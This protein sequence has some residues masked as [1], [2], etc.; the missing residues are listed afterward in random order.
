MNS[1]SAKSRFFVLATV[2]TF[3]LTCSLWAQDTNQTSSHDSAQQNSSDQA[4]N[5]LPPSKT[6]AETSKNAGEETDIQKRLNASAT[7]LDEIMKVPEKGIPQDAF[8]GAKCVVVIPST[9]KVAFVFGGEHGKGVATCRATK[10]ATSPW[11]APVPVD[12][13][14]GSWGLQIG[15]EAVDLVMLVMSEK[16]LDALLTNKF[17][18][19]ASASGAAGPVGRQASG[20]TDWKFKSDVLTYSRARGAFAGIDLNGAVVKQDKDETAVLYGKV[21]PFR[22]VLSGTVPAPPSARPF[23]AAVGKYS[24]EAHQTRDS[25]AVASP[26]SE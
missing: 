24:A 15:G 18:I 3:A 5:P 11:S 2:F 13:T 17:K 26:S 16:G 8:N 10:T 7:V 25:G 14:G 4:G 21:L 22:E 12:L 19:G 6:A 23:L 9:V 20:S 1:T